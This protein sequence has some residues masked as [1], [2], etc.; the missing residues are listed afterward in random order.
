[1]FMNGD[2]IPQDRA[3]TVRLFR[4]SSAR[5]HGYSH[6]CFAGKGRLMHASA[7]SVQNTTFIRF[8]ITTVAPLFHCQVCFPVLFTI[9]I[10]RVQSRPCTGVRFLMARQSGNLEATEEI[11]NDRCV[12]SDEKLGR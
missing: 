9:C 4:F 11:E 12:Y 2:G 10:P 5:G 6:C 1:M 8:K 3:E 7:H